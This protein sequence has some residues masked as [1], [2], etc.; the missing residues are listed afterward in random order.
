[1]HSIPVI[2]IATQR[3]NSSDHSNRNFAV[4]SKAEADAAATFLGN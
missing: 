2:Q 1:M 3:E 4:R